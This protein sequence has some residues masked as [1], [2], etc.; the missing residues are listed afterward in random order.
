MVVMIS[1]ESFSHLGLRSA[2]IDLTLSF[3]QASLDAEL[4]DRGEIERNDWDD[5]V[6]FA[7]LSIADKSAFVINPTPYEAAGLVDH[8]PPGIAHYGFVVNDIDVAVSN[9]KEAGESV[10]M[11]PFVVGEAAYAFCHGPD[12]TRIELVEN[13]E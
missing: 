9:W 3:L 11:E 6:A 7:V 5:T 12:G 13:F 2:D 4:L 8:I 10:L 1:P